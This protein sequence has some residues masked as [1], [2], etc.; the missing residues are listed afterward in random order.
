MYSV[1]NAFKE[2]MR[3]PIQEHRVTG[4]IGSLSFSEANIVDGSFSISNQSTDSNDVVLGSCYVG[5]LN[6][7]FTG[8]NILYGD[9]INKVITPTFALNLGDSWES[10]PLGV[11]TVKEAKHTEHGVQVTAY[12]NMIKFDKKFKKSHFQSLSGL[13]NIIS[14]IC[15]DAGV[16]LGMTSAQIGALPNGSETGIKIY[17][18]TG[19]KSEFANDI[20]TLRDLLFWVAQT[21][22]C[23]ATINR[24]GQLVF[25]QYTQ[26][27]VDVISDTQRI[28]GATFADYITHY[29]G[30]Y[31]ENLDDNTED[32]YGYTAAAL[33]EE[34]NE[35][36]AEIAADQERIGELDADLIE[37][38]RKL[39]N[40]ECTQQ[41]YD[42]AVAEIDAELT[43][44]K[45][46]VKQLN[47]R[48]K[49]LTQAIAQ[50]GN[51]GSDMVLGANPLLMD[52]NITK[53]DTERRAVLAALNNISYTPFQASVLCGCVYDLGDV[54]QFSGGLYNSAT[55]SFGCVM[56]YVYTHNG[57]MELEG[58]GVD[59]SMVV[60]RNKTLKSAD[61]ADRNAY[62]A[63]NNATHN[64][65]GFES[66]IDPESQTPST[67]GKDGDMHVVLTPPVKIQ[68]HINNSPYWYATLLR[69]NS[70]GKYDITVT[71]Y[72]DDAVTPFSPIN[73]AIFKA[74]GFGGAG[75]YHISCKMQ[76]QGYTPNA[77]GANNM[78][79]YISYD[80][81]GIYYTGTS[82]YGTLSTTPQDTFLLNLHNDNNEHE[83]SFDFVID[84]AH[85]SYIQNKT[86][87]LT[88]VMD[89]CWKYRKNPPEG[90]A[91]GTLTIKDLEITGANVQ[92]ETEMLGVEVKVGDKWQNI[93]YVNK[94]SQTQGTTGG[95]EIAEIQN[96]NGEKTK[97]YQKT[98]TPNPQGT[99]TGEL[100]SITI[101][102]EVF[103]VGGNVDDVKVD[104]V[105]V[106]TNK[107][108]NIN[109]MTGATTQA[110]GTKGLVPAPTTGDVAK[111]L[112][113]DG[114]WELIANAEE[115]TQ[116]AYDALPSA[117][118]T[119][120][121]KVY[122]IKDGGGSG[123]GGG[124]G[125]SSISEL[126]D[127]DLNDL[128]DGQ[129][130]KYNN[131][132]QKWENANESGGGGGVEML[133]PTPFIYSETEEQVGIWIDGKPLYEVTK[134]YQY[135]SSWLGKR[136]SLNHSISNID[137]PLECK[138]RF[139][140]TQSD[141]LLGEYVVRDSDDTYTSSTDS[142]AS[143]LALENAFF[144][145][146]QFGFIM[147]NLYQYASINLIVT[148]RYTKTTDTA[149]Q[150]GFKAYGFSPV[151][152]S[153][154][155][156]EI[157]VWRDG[158]PLYQKTFRPTSPTEANTAQV[159]QDISSLNIDVP[160]NLFGNISNVPINWTLDSSNGVS[161]FIT[162]AKTGIAMKVIN[163]LL[164][165]ITCNI[166]IQY[167]KTTDTAGS[168]KY[169]T[170]GTPSVHYDGEERVIG[171]W[172]GK[173]LY[174]KVFTISNTIANVQTNTWTAIPDI[175]DSNM[176]SVIKCTLIYWD[177]G[178]D[179]NI[180]VNY[181]LLA[182]TNR[183][184]F[185][186][187]LAVM[188]TRNSM[189]TYVAGNKIIVEYT[190]LSD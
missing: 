140:N 113:G 128:S 34:L 153:D 51:D 159:V 64:T 117:E 61:K 132:S 126:T 127:V 180:T 161:C 23:F 55:D 138:I 160:V 99:A 166:T 36:N 114:T 33:T 75:T 79:I 158:K 146:T 182:S 28:E 94:V 125:A 164:T 130:L 100:K 103:S 122:Y 110:N 106:V 91:S 109:T 72:S 57:G 173:P 80:S 35:T 77:W 3:S 185:N 154:T 76:F 98:V 167:T 156:R 88:I 62:V 178:T 90:Y 82:A 83:Y 58:F 4:T 162:S 107:V 137:K 111:V 86:M 67:I 105:S 157:G 135:D 169:T 175:D 151:I 108:A 152:Y 145:Q 25:R 5:Q 129:I 43:P 181:D 112:K 15:T 92:P 14:Q 8:I 50:A 66:Y 89:R 85:G 163:S 187:K 31:L 143:N 53:R 184:Y 172:F 42:E 179:G 74:I 44:L 96:T 183:T 148:F 7:E 49:W 52:S 60:V 29:V 144:N 27:V 48:V 177:S 24:A 171:T 21:M 124:G 73:A 118:K 13:Y 69:Q 6:A 78:G 41:E 20:T 101:G 71:G 139:F 176:K 38:K 189:V 115:I 1:S 174:R 56:S 170:L 190:K 134:T 68:R 147:G 39:D 116:A 119:T 136:N 120:A 65:T 142:F 93:D 186:N 54:I 18:S 95:T 59:P 16:T 81:N 22:G 102:S 155:E 63:A 26:N 133:A 10:V 188:H 40:H 37:W 17:G 149:W 30:I 45:K 97:I 11:F 141:S 84:N 70:N 168:G 123:G 165:N 19:A 104:N 87:Y 12:D 131:T 150:G 46:E 9:W 2:K 47:K 121:E 32:Y